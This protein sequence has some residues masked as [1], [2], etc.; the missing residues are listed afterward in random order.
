MLKQEMTM[1]YWPVVVV[2]V[3][4]ASVIT[5]MYH[6]ELVAFVS[7]FRK[8]VDHNE[9]LK[10]VAEDWKQTGYIDF[11][12]PRELRANPNRLAEPNFFYLTIEEYRL[13]STIGG[14]TAVER[15]WRRGS[16]TDAREV[17]HNYYQFLNDHPEKA[18]NEE[19]RR[20]TGSPRLLDHP[21]AH[22]G[23]K[24]SNVG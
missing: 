18:F 1:S 2:V 13:V 11:S 7:Q 22:R 5:Y 16:L 19:P 8:E 12:V 23:H 10:N 15:R 3:I 20:L 6:R 14:G 4:V 17:A 9:A 24:Q 21:A